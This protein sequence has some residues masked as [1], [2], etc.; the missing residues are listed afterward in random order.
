MRRS[1]NKGF[2]YRYI[3][4]VLS[5]NNSKI[6]E[7]S[8]LISPRELEIKDTTESITSASYLDCISVLTIESLLL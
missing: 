5:V 1:L 7:L 3:D 4:D 2:T 8:D 6:S